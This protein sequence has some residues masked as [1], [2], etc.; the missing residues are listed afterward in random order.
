MAKWEF[1]ALNKYSEIAHKGGKIHMV[2][3]C[4]KLHGIT[5]L[6]AQAS[7]DGVHDVAPAPTGDF[8]FAADFRELSKAGKCVAGGI[9][10]TALVNL[11]PEA[12]EDYVARLLNDVAPGTGFLAS[13][14]DTVPFG[15]P[16]ENL[17]AVIRALERHG[18]QPLP[19]VS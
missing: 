4:G 9:D 3:M 18:R 7:F 6:L 5:D 14:G 1:P 8:D 19:R 16:V 11:P 17:K 10:A 13:C 15:T 2:H 12:L